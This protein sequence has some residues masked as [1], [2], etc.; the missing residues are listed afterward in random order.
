M[1]S[2]PLVHPQDIRSELVRQRDIERDTHGAARG[3]GQLRPE[4]WPDDSVRLVALA[5]NELVRR[6]YER[7]SQ[8]TNLSI[9][10]VDVD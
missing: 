2:S 5:V 7:D 6:Q 3:I 4:N 10:A 1:S 9:G 8:T